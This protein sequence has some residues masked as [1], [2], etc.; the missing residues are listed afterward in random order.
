M[1]ESTKDSWERKGI[2][3]APDKSLSWSQSHGMIPTPIKRDDH[4]RVFFSARN[5]S[6]QSSIGWFDV[7][8][9]DSPRVLK[10]SKEPILIPGELGCFDDNGV[11]PSCVVELGNGDIAMYYIG[12]NPGS[13]TRVNLFGG[14]ALSHDGGETFT[15]WS[16]APILERIKTDPY[17]NTAPWVV[18]TL[19]EYRM[20]YVSGIKWVDK[21]SP[22]YN[23]KVAYS[24]D[25]LVWERSG[26]VVLDFKSPIETALARPYVI[27]ENGVW[28]MWV[29]RR[30]GEYAIAYAESD[31]GI[32][33]TRKDELYGLMPTGQGDERTMTEYSAVIRDSGNL[34]MFY[35]GDEYGKAGIL[36]ARMKN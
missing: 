23:I 1:D 33:W 24:S 3:F 28:R 18:K 9:S 25:G 5:K 12:W 36:L 34:W 30:V 10:V 4:W 15:R 27:V 13:T 29:T 14:L 35:N 22:R 6:N 7:D 20:Y 26:E 11:S 16:K 2:I 31:D 17:M 21:D 32:S 19:A 8:F